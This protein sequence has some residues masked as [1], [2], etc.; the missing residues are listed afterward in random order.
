MII[1]VRTKNAT[2]ELAERL[3]ARGFAAAAI[4]GDVAQVQR[5]RTID[6]LRKGKLDILV[7]TDV[8]ARGLDVERISH[9]INHD[10]PTDTESYVHR[11]GRTGR[12]GRSGQAISFVTPREN[13]LLRAIEKANRT[14][15]E[16][17]NLPTVEDVNAF[18]VAKFTEAIT[19]ALGD[20]QL[21]HL[22]RARAVL[23]AGARRPGGRHR[24]RHRRTRP[25][26]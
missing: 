19:Q 26:R 13:Y 3:R 14:T 23:R 15:L 21:G 7:A 11:I 5:E 12:A 10:I 1:F 22:P 4:N 20:P 17:M 25:G 6:Q 16:Q 24:R 18:R 9:V 8:A 2:E